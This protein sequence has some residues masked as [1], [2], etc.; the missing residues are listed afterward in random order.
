[1]PRKVYTIFLEKEDV[2]HLQQAIDYY[3]KVQLGLGKRFDKMFHRR[4]KH[5]PK[6]R[7]SK[8]DMTIFVVYQ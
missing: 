3:N 4:L 1:M 8:Y 6:I 2:E 5:S 7:I